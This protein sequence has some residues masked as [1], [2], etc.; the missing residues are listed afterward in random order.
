MKDSRTG[1]FRG[2]GNVGL[3]NLSNIKERKHG[4][5]P[6]TSKE[7]LASRPGGIFV[8]AVLLV[9]VMVPSAGSWPVHDTGQTQCFIYDETTETSNEGA[10]PASGVLFYGQ[11]GN[12]LVNAPS[13]TKLDAQ[14]NDLP[15]SATG[16]TM[17]RDNITGLIWGGQ[18]RQRWV[19]GLFECK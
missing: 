13:F 7:P 2:A 12:Y 10:Y 3:S 1:C 16:W 18:T 14:G 17:V 5:P 4:G 15:D 11:D 6:V 9:L 19:E 8:F